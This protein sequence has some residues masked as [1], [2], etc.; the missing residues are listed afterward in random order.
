MQRLIIH[1]P[2]GP[3]QPMELPIDDVMVFIGEQ[4]TGKSTVAKLVYFFK[5][6]VGNLLDK[7]KNG[8][9]LAFSEVEITIKEKFTGVAE[10]IKNH[11]S[12]L[13]K[14]YY[15]DK[16]WI[17]IEVKK[18]HTY[19]TL[20]KD[21]KESSSKLEL[22]FDPIEPTL[23]AMFHEPSELLFIPSGRNVTVSYD[24]IF[25]MDFY[26]S[27]KNRN[28][29][30]KFWE[31]ILLKF[32]QR[33]EEVKSDFRGK[34]LNELVHRR[35]DIYNDIELNTIGLPLGLIQLILKGEYYSNG[36][37]EKIYFGE[38][39]EDYVFLDNASSGQQ[40]AIRILQ[41]LFLMILN[42]EKFYL[43]IEEPEAHLYPTAQRHLMEMIVLMVNAT[44]NQVLIT[45][46]S[47]YT[48]TSFNNLLYA[49][50]VG[51]DNPE[52]ADVVQKEL[53]LDPLKFNAYRLSSRKEDVFCQSIFD[54]ETGLIGYNS[55][56][57]VSEDLAG[58]FDKLLEL[59]QNTLYEQK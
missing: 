8:T 53:W 39:T 47:P 11:D 22:P 27:L 56:D 35:N 12:I 24:E 45:T 15:S 5:G 18:G 21:L 14:Y 4:A 16:T 3:L 59:R 25:K 20:S 2:F 42:K 34:S 58:D 54:K 32:F 44:G 31:D 46:H 38:G 50:K 28:K 52:A 57:D 29:P 51:K 55:I 6:I 13:M 1:K 37:G 40:E 41:N 9:H 48:L 36:D 33:T 23:R 30:K 7:Y 49:F 43:I 17:V 26:A 19:I 10:G